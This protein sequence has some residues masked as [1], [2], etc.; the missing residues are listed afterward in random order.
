M[1]R[2]TIPGRHGTGNFLGFWKDASE[3]ERWVDPNWNVMERAL[4]ITYLD[5]GTTE[6][7][8]RGMAV[9]RVCSTWNGSRDLTDGTWIWPSGLSHYLK[10]H[11][12]RPPQ[13]FID[14]VISKKLPNPRDTMSDDSVREM[15]SMLGGT[16]EQGAEAVARMRVIRPVFEKLSAL[17][18]KRDIVVAIHLQEIIHHACDLVSYLGEEFDPDLVR[19]ILNTAT[20]FAASSAPKWDRYTKLHAPTV[21]ANIVKM[22]SPQGKCDA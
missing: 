14:Y 1:I 22:N 4:V 2:S 10:E 5:A 3:P 17:A 20:G 8:Y 6:E 19:G 7:S 21:N 13:S 9:C 12:V 18:E 15:A 16:P 11:D